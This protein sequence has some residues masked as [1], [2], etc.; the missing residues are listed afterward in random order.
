MEK[1]TI[2]IGLPV[3]NGEQFLHN[4]LDS[5]LSQSFSDFELIIS[6]NA[7]TDNTQKICEKYLEKDN[8][9]RY[10]RQSK[11]MG[12]LWNFNFVLHQA[13][14][15]FFVW[16]AVDDIWDKS[17]LAKNISVLQLK[18]NVVGS[19]SRVITY[20]P[21]SNVTPILGLKNSLKKVFFPIG[22]T[23]IFSITGSYE[24]KVRYYL[25]RSSCSIIYSVFRTE[26]LRRGFVPERF[27]GSDWAVNLNLLKFGD[28][29]IIDEDLMFKSNQGESSK[30]IIS[31]SRTY[32]DSTLKIIF[33]W[34]PFT[35]WCAKN[36]G[37]KIFLKNIDYFAMLN[38]IGLTALLKKIWLKI[39]RKN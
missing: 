22:P 29:H 35:S 1:T 20:G 27:L 21:N 5:I 12:P 3:F 15:E 30:D 39:R 2:C 26:Q 19:L 32:N 23:G 25:K 33:P 14:S 37:T 24:K 36:L 38:Y 13:N 34:L 8:R 31:L 28:I 9:I 10:I 6:D 18:Q 4:R 16:A 17:F 11:N 7:S